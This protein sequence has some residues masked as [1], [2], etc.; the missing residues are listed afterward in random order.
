MPH[1]SV[2]TLKAA[3]LRHDNPR[4]WPAWGVQRVHVYAHPAGAAPSAARQAVAKPPAP[5]GAAT[6]A[7][8]PSAG[9]AAEAGVGPHAYICSPVSEETGEAAAWP[10]PEQGP[11]VRHYLSHHA[12]GFGELVSR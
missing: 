6:P 11:Y 5:G 9:A 3:H 2:G 10:W 4:A 1:R 7:A 8:A 12:A